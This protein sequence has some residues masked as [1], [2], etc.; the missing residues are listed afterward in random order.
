M[1]HSVVTEFL[2]TGDGTR[3]YEDKVQLEKNSAIVAK[4]EDEKTTTQLYMYNLDDE[5]EAIVS[6]CKI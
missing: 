3:R 4:K 5:M 1:R 2:M 6:W